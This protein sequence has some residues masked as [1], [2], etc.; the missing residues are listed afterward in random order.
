MKKRK[1]QFEPA[2]GTASQPL[3]NAVLSNPCFPRKGNIRKGKG[4]IAVPACGGSLAEAKKAHVTKPAQSKKQYYMQTQTWLI[5][6]RQPGSCSPLLEDFG[7]CPSFTPPPPPPQ[8]NGCAVPKGPGYGWLLGTA[9]A[10]Y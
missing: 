9:V 8:Q 7:C 2:F 1:I 5:L 6:G 4:Y 10:P 3:H